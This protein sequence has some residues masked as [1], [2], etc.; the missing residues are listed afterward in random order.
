MVCTYNNGLKDG[1][2]IFMRP[3]INVCIEMREKCCKKGD[4]T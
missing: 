4:F 3:L 1:V 2:N